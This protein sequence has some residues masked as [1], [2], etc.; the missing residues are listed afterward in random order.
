MCFW[1]VGTAF[2]HAPVTTYL[3]VPP[4]ENSMFKVLFSGMNTKG[5]VRLEVG[6]SRVAGPSCRIII[7]TQNQKTSVRGERLRKLGLERYR[8]RVCG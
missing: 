3:C 7:V 5:L 6:T 8:T 4:S 2:L 1:D